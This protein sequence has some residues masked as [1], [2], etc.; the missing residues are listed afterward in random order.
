MKQFEMGK[1]YKF[2]ANDH[3][4]LSEGDIFTPER[5]DEYGDAIIGDWYVF[6]ERLGSGQVIEIKENTMFTKDDLKDGMRVEFANGVSLYWFRSDLYDD[7]ITLKFKHNDGFLD[8][9]LRNISHGR[10]SKLGNVVKVTDRDG[11]AVFE[12]EETTELT[13]QEVADKLGVPVSQLKI[14]GE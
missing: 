12:R 8:N 5:V 3:S 2:L 1:T 9:C 11:T 6:C 13:M 14:K 7:C 4:L 10:A